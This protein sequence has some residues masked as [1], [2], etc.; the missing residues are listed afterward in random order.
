MPKPDGLECIAKIRELGINK[1]IILT[2]GSMGVGDN[3]ALQS[4]D[5]TQ[6]L[7]KPYDFEELLKMVDELL[8]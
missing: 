8:Y 4:L 6:I 7:V 5:I 2:T 3:P 1:P